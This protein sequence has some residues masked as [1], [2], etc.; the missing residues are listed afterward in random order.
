MV[1]DSVVLVGRKP[2]MNYVLATTLPLAEGKRVILK[3]RGRAIA[4][5]VDVVEVVRR[6]FVQNAVVEK[7][8]IGTEE[9]KVGNDGRQRNVSTIEI[10]LTQPKASKK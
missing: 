9:G 6:R 10:I 5:A 1:E 8:N 4:K 2:T 7:I 3:A